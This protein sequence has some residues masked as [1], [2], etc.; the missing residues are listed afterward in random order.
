MSAEGA[1]EEKSFTPSRK[2]RKGKKRKIC[3]RRVQKPF[4]PE[5]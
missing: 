1:G 4:P 2:G 3:F 5:T